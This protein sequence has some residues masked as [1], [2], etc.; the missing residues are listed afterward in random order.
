MLAGAAAIVLDRYQESPTRASASR[1]P[2]RRAAG[3]GSRVAA[4]VRGS[5]QGGI[6]DTDYVNRSLPVKKGSAIA[7]ITTTRR[8]I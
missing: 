8:S 5:S 6:A 7:K 2:A 3:R 1:A 4:A